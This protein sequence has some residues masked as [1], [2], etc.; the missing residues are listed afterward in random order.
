[1]ERHQQQH[2]QDTQPVQ[3]ATAQLIWERGGKGRTHV[4]L[5][6]EFFGILSLALNPQNATAHQTSSTLA[7]RPVL[8]PVKWIGPI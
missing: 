7:I 6:M 3:V 1:M 8:S 4:Y 2:R 5:R